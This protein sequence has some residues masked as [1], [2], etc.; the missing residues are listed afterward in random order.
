MFSSRD[1]NQSDKLHV[2]LYIQIKEVIDA[3]INNGKLSPGDK[4]PSESELKDIFKVSRTTIRLAI[5]ELIYE[6]KLKSEQGKGTFVSRPKM[7]QHLP[8]LSSFTEEVKIKG[9]TPGAEIIELK[10]RFPNREIAEN[11]EIEMD[12]E[13]IVLKRLRT[14]DGEVVGIHTSYLNSNLLEDDDFE[15]KNL[16][17]SLYDILENEYEIVFTDAIETIEAKE[18]NEEQSELLRIEK[19]SPLLYLERITMN[20][21]GQPVEFCKIAYTADSYKYKLRL[22]RNNFNSNERK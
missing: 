16:T 4:I 3:A 8:Y 18:A 12:T 17:G 6:G 21:S 5:K 20:E 13:I 19:K 9:H 11:L 15:N 7:E 22:T 1:I 2:P 14:V 10:R